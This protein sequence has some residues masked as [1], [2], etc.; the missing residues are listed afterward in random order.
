MKGL[1]ECPDCGKPM[2]RKQ[3]PCSVCMDERPDE[4]SADLL[5]ALEAMVERFKVDL[6]HPYKHILREQALAAIAAAKGQS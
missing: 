2:R 5:E 3:A 1:S 6:C 4:I